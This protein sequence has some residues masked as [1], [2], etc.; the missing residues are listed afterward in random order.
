MSS[1]I[2]AVIIS[3]FMLIFAIFVKA[4]KKDKKK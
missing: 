4:D 1:L 2:A 3:T